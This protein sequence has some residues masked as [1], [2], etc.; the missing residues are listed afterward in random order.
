MESET[1]GSVK[2]RTLV[3]E[4]LRS[5]ETVDA[6]AKALGVSPPELRALATKLRMPATF[7]K[8]ERGRTG[9]HPCFVSMEGKE[10][11]GGVVTVVSRAANSPRGNAR[12]EVRFRGC[13]HT[14][15]FEGI[16]LRE[17]RAAPKCRIC[18]D[19]GQPGGV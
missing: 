7:A 12:W 13:G 15:V 17:K 9:D 16:K 2:S 19:L 18:G 3:Y 11:F 5:S 10:L 4:T 8:L 14:D 1:K 6:A